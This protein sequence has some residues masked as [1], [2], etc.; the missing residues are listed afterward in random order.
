MLYCVYIYT[1]SFLAI[2]KDA[3]IKS[4]IVALNDSSN[5]DK[6]YFS[7]YDIKNIIKHNVDYIIPR[8]M[9][10]KDIDKYIMDNKKQLH[11]KV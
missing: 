3:D 2:M 1:K 8:S 9:Y 10:I 7:L 6:R 11:Q 4:C 5:L